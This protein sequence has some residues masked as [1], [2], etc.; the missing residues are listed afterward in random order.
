MEGSVT[1]KR[2]PEVFG[3]DVAAVAPGKGSFSIA[4]RKAVT[5]QT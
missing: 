5:W 2:D 3:G 1:P 4:L